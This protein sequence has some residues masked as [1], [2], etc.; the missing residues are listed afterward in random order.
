MFAQCAIAI[1]LLLNK[2]PTLQR[3]LC[4]LIQ[5]RL[6]QCTTGSHLHLNLIDNLFFAHILQA[7]D[8]SFLLNSASSY[9]CFSR[10]YFFRSISSKSLSLSIHR[11]NSS[12]QLCII[13]EFNCR[14]QIHPV[15]ILYVIYTHHFSPV[16]HSLSS[17]FALI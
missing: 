3:I 5:D 14:F 4:F 9:F 10:L 2:M 6:I 15:S 12:C 1:H 17:E 8:F 7:L 13:I 11:Q 16:P